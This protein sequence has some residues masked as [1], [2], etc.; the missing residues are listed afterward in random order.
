[1]TTVQPI[2][3]R[4]RI[5]EFSLSAILAVTMAVFLFF[6]VVGL[7]S[8]CTVDIG[9]TATNNEHVSFLADNVFR[10]LLFLLVFF[11]IAR[12]VLLLP[13]GGEK[14]RP[15]LLKGALVLAV[16]GM[17]C[18]WVLSTHTLPCADAQTILEE[19]ARLARGNYESLIATSYFRI[20]PF[21]LGY[22][23]YAEGFFRVFSENA[24]VAI[25]LV[26][27]L[28]VDVA[29]LA[30]L[31]ITRELFHDD[32]LE[33][34]TGVLLL[35]CLQPV[36]L[37]TFPYGVLPGLGL[38]LGGVYF[39]VAYMRDHAIWRLIPAALLLALAIALRKNCTI[40]L[41]ACC[42]GL[43]LHVLKTKQLSGLMGIAVMAVLAWLIPFGVQKSY[44]VRTDAVFGQGTPQGAWLVT[45][46]EESSMCCGWFGSYTT[47]VFSDNGFD[48]EKTEKQIAQDFSERMAVF[49]DRPRYLASF[50]YKKVVSQ[51]NEPAYQSIW[52]SAVSP[53][54]G[55]P[56]P[57]AESLLFGEAGESM[58]QYFNDY[59]QFV[60][61]CFALGLAFLVKKERR[62]TDAVVILPLTVFGA[63]LY[64]ALFEAKAQYA[65][66]YLPMMLPFAAYGAKRILSL[67]PVRKG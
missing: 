28:W 35:F 10:N 47:T 45:G 49:A 34:L 32:R 20:F 51:W 5:A 4:T 2:R 23:L 18:W 44:E 54:E 7:V 3:L 38:S 21:Q 6:A 26:N 59:V 29:F 58:K 12:I 64:H 13:A 67:L 14:H 31:A 9:F 24:I 63:F 66:V 33:L 25:Q 65:L 8:T 27:V 15:L 41:I 48:R 36:F 22:L 11:C 57:L 61:L 1:M 16:T 37:C 50:L 43:A 42:I 55:K 30:L 39:V 62:M 19:A 53:H 60:Y 56:A 40:L 52:S 46:F 17:G